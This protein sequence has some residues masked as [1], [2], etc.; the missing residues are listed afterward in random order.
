MARF[1]PAPKR[2]SWDG[3]VYEVKQYLKKVANDPE[4]IDIQNC[5]D[6]YYDKKEGWLVA[7]EY[8][9]NNAFGGRVR[10]ANWFVIRHGRVIAMKDI[11]AYKLQ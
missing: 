6:I 3:S 4:S 11:N 8:L 9:G 10:N 1:G 2:S 7:C 5:T